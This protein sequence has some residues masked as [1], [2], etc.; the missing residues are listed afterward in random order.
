MNQVAIDIVDLQSAA[1]RIERRPDPL[2]PMIG[3]PQLRGD[4]YVLPLNRPRLE[5]LAHRVTDGLFIAVPLRAVEM[6]ETHSQCTRD[7]LL[8]RDEIRNQ[9]AKSDYGDRTRSVG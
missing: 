5:C 2:W 4:E 3:V 1:T 7:G 9:R 8:G 6:P